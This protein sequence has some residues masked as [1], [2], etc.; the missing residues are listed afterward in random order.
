MRRWPSRSRWD[1]SQVKGEVKAGQ[2]CIAADVWDPA[3]P[4][5]RMWPVGRPE[6]FITPVNSQILLSSLNQSW[7]ARV[8]EHVSASHLRGV[9]WKH[10]WMESLWFN[11]LYQSI[12]CSG[13]ES[14][15]P[16]GEPE[17]KG[18]CSR[19]RYNNTILLWVTLAHTRYRHAGTH[20]HTHTRGTSA[21][22]ASVCSLP[23]HNSH[24]SFFPSVK[25]SEASHWLVCV[26]QTDKQ[27]ERQT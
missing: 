7:N 21:K 6:L 3:C 17:Q 5:C 25:K 11:Y 16:Q 26:R 23:H 18:C 4:E 22:V 1:N 2:T 15:W 13:N 19:R 24:T 27:R 9:V 10:V 20:T 8:T 12:C 14:S